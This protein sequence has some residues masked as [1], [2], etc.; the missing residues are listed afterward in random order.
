VRTLAVKL[1]SFEQDRSFDKPTDSLNAYEKVLRGRQLL[2]DTEFSANLDARELFKEAIDLDQAYA[3]AHVGLGL[4]HIAD[5]YWGWVEDPLDALDAS[6]RHALRALNINPDHAGARALWSEIWWFQG[7]LARAE[8]EIS[9]A[10][11]LNP[12]KSHM[13]DGRL[14]LYSGKVIEAIRALEL[15]IRIDPNIRAFVPLATAYYRNS[16]APSPIT[17]CSGAAVRAGR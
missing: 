14:L 5:L 9:R 16:Q 17:G 6:E 7:D 15:A 1:T 13:I 8:E 4:T 11:A 10:L 12:N 3:D 2:S